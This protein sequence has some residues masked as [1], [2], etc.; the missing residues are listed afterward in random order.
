MIFER[1]KAIIE[2]LRP[3]LGVFGVVNLPVWGFS[4]FKTGESSYSSQELLELR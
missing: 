3:F 2:D 1:I 4:A